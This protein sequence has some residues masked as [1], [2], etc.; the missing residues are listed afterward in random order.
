MGG[1]ETHVCP[2]WLTCLYLGML[3]AGHS[4]QTCRCHICAADGLDLFNSTEF[5]LGQQLW[6]NDNHLVIQSSA[7]PRSSAFKRHPQILVHSNSNMRCFNHCLFILQSWALPGN[8]I[9]W[10]SQ[11]A[12]PWKEMQYNDLLLINMN[13][14]SKFASEGTNINYD[15]CDSGFK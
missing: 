13:Y 5:W 9:S 10:I 12:C 3:L 6:G 15:A 1:A 8:N 7:Y 4:A 14:L 2:V 11:R